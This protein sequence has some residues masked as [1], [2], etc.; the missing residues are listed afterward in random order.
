[1]QGSFNNKAKNAAP[2]K[3]KIGIALQGGGAYGIYAKGALETLLNS[4][5]A[6]KTEIKAVT[7]TSA[8]AMNGALLVHGLNK[9]GAPQALQNLDQFWT[10]TKTL[11]HTFSFINGLGPTL[12]PDWP[13]IPTH[14]MLLFTFAQAALPQGYVLRELKQT[15]DQ[16]INDITFLQKGAAQLFVNAVREN[17]QNQREHV[18]FT[19]NGLTTDNIVTSGALEQ[20]GGWVV[21]GQKHYDGAY[22]RNPCFDDILKADITD[23]LV[24]TLQEKPQRPTTARSQDDSRQANHPKPGHS[25]ITSEIHD[26]LH[27]VQQQRPKLNLHSIELNVAP[28]WN[29][30]SRINTDPTWLNT[31]EDLGHKDAENW[32]KDNLALL[33]KKSSYQI[34]PKPQSPLPKKP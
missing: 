17:Q 31:L 11:G 5:F 20:F 2:Q 28:H 13:N 19:G 27:Y 21:N 12:N 22:W 14:K 18:V 15:L 16:E 4:K 3:T 23:L 1:M 33:G 34:N 26:H 24:I 29:E 9:G 6:T 32:L 10:N 7:G 30:T 8:G 25:L